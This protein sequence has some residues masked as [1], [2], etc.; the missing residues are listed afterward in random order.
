MNILTKK[1]IAI[2]EK[3]LLKAGAVLAVRAWEAAAFYEI[4]LHLPD[5]DMRSWQSVQHMKCKVAEATY[6]DYT[7]AGWDAET[8]TCTL[9]ID[10]AHDGPGAAWAAGLAQGHTIHHMGIAS[11]HHKPVEDHTLICLGDSSSLGHF[12]ALQQLA[13]TGSPLTGAIAFTSQTHIRLFKEYFT[14][15]LVTVEAGRADQQEGL[16]E[17]LTL[18][19]FEKN[20]T[21]YITG[22][23][24]T[25]VQLRRQLRQ[26]KD[27]G[28]SI[29]VNGFWS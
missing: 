1:A 7:P 26:R 22:H 27:I 18:Q 11:A 4:D 9:Y 3:P 16:S 14:L 25:A 15:P 24:P 8:R 5:T 29:K 28:G 23:I 17:W 6:R 10:A 2:L 12:L 21:A 20:T 19:T 13:G